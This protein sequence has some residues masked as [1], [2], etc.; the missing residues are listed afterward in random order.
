MKLNSFTLVTPWIIL[1][2]CEGVNKTF[3]ALLADLRLSWT[4]LIEAERRFFVCSFNALETH[5]CLLKVGQGILRER[6]QKKN[7][8]C[9][10]EALFRECFRV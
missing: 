9:F 1:Q 2:E 5:F 8:L 6:Q 10:G 7:T 4:G 3:R